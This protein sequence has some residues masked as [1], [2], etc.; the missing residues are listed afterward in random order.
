MAEENIKREEIK[1]NIWKNGNGNYDEEK[2]EEQKKEIL[3]PS[4]DIV[5]KNAPQENILSVLKL[6]S[7]GTALR[8][9]IEDIVKGQ[10]GGLLVVDSP[11]LYK[12]IEGGFRVNCKFTPQKLTEL[13][14]MDGAIIL[15][16]DLK[17]I[18][19]ANTLLVPNISILSR[20]TGTRHKAAE[21]VAKQ[22]STLAI[23]IS[24]RRGTITV[25]YKNMR[26][27]LKETQEILRRA[28]ESLQILEKQREMFDELLSNLNVLE[29]TNL[30][31]LNDVCS[32]VQKAELILKIA[33]IIKRY[34]IELGK[35]GSI[36]KIRIR[37]LLKDV[38]KEEEEV[39]SDYSK[40]KGK[41]TKNLLSS[42][43]LDELLETGNIILAFGLSNTDL[44]SVKSTRLLKK[45]GLTESEALM[46]V[47][48]FNSLQ[49]IIDSPT[50]KIE[51]ILKSE[52][53]SNL[54]RKSLTEMKHQVMLGKKI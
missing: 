37:E 44:I 7:P 33:S 50:E 54:L 29:F 31:T 12:I 18:I 43:S 51:K 9:A 28:T 23:A 26:Y 42:L 45:I 10:M 39:I 8:E 22:L 36:I 52:K 49:E 16:K 48:E 20:E 41:K 30:I 14:K 40:I 11:D 27:K 19:Y 53:K 4:K 32:F 38:E 34:V 15:S 17:K 5:I 6:I 3:D 25:Y 46:L 21:R 13:S 35:E 24:E 1:R 2:G 47:K